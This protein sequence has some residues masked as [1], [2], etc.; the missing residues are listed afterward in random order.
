L[1]FISSSKE[2][3]LSDLELISHYLLEIFFFGQLIVVALSVLAVLVFVF[4]KAGVG[5]VFS[6]VLPAY[7]VAETGHVFNEFLASIAP[8]H[9]NLDV[10]SQTE[11][12]AV[13]APCRIILTVS[14]GGSTVF[15]LIRRQSGKPVLHTNAVVY[16]P[17]MLQ[18]A[19]SLP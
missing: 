4:P 8:L 13:A 1:S 6:S 11:L 10:V 18:R 9:R 16:L 7:T 2:R 12:P 3:S 19:W 14:K 17:Q 15:L 5:D